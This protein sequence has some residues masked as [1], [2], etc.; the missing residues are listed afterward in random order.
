MTHAKTGKDFKYRPLTAWMVDAPDLGR[1]AK[2]SF[3][4]K[5]YTCSETIMASDYEPKR[6]KYVHC[7]ASFHCQVNLPGD[8]VQHYP[9][10]SLQILSASPEF[11]LTLHQT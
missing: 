3:L 7:V 5:S 2:L 6:S 1:S 4:V 11:D 9:S 10:L 8:I